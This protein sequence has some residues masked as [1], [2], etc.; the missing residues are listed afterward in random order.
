MNIYHLLKAYR[1]APGWLGYSET[2][3]IFLFTHHVR[4]LQ[5]RLEGVSAKG[6]KLLYELFTSTY[7][8][9]VTNITIDS[10]LSITLETSFDLLLES[11]VIWPITRP[12]L[13]E[14]DLFSRNIPFWELFSEYPNNAQEI[15]ELLKSTSVALIGVGGFGSWL[16]YLLAG[17]GVGHLT[18]I[19]DDIVTRS[20][21][22]RQMLFNESDI[23][24][25]KV[26]AAS[27]RLKS[28][29]PSLHIKTFQQR[30]SAKNDLS[31]NLSKINLVIAPIGLPKPGESFSELIIAILEACSSEKVAVMFAGSGFVGP[32][33]PIP[34]L[35]ALE[36]FIS[37]PS[38]SATLSTIPSQ[39]NTN[40]NNIQPALACRLGMGASLCAWEATRYLAGIK[41]YVINQIIS[42]DTLHYSSI[43]IITR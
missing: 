29:F 12:T 23:G 28:V 14:V 21:L 41:C 20:N 5:L 16:A 13:S 38:V 27:N 43:N 6:A 7:N 8:M 30:I 4:C 1:L 32:I 19:D 3:N 40:Y 33:F 9:P 34:S 25:P 22:N 10:E 18:L 11:G 17:S 35:H 26:I 31:Q 37:Q 15:H 2:N 42:P 36:E 24:I 39:F